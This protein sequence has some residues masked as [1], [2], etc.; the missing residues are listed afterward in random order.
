MV[1]RQ[2]V[3]Q[4][5]LNQ[6]PPPAIVIWTLTLQPMKPEESGDTIHKENS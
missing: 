1:A 3:I 2:F 5:D 4:V 6:N